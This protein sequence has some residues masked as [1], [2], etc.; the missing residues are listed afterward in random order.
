MNPEQLQLR[1]ISPPIPPSVH[2][3]LQLAEKQSN[4]LLILGF[5]IVVIVVAFLF[6]HLGKK[7][8]SLLLAHETAL[9]DLFRA[10]SL[11]TPD[12]GLQ[13][14]GELSDILRRYIEKRLNIKTTRQT[15]KEFFSS[16][17]KNPNQAKKMAE[18]Q[19]VNLQE[20]MEKCDMAKFACCAPD[21]HSME[22][23]ETA[24]QD[25]IVATREPTKGGK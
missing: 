16:I 5:I 21:L 20:C 9:A 15:T 13:Y 8:G 14:A 11:M 17:T 4:T 12:L 6:F 22:K 23:M 1:D 10:R 18:D 2:P 24:V 25:F 3:L 19:M 7:K